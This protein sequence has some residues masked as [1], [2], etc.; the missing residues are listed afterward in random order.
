MTA[1][2]EMVKALFSDSDCWTAIDIGPIA[3]S[4]RLSLEQHAGFA[5]GQLVLRLD[6]NQS[7]EYFFDLEDY[8]VA[9]QLAEGLQAWADF[10]ETRHAER[11]ERR[12]RDAAT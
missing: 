2:Y 1:L 8:H 5:P 3:G 4:D 12:S 9:R 7:G 10:A 6:A 11:E